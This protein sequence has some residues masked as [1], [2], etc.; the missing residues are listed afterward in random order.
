MSTPTARSQELDVNAI[1]EGTG[2]SPIDAEWHTDGI[3]PRQSAVH[4]G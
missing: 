1:V 3:A 2:A 4:S